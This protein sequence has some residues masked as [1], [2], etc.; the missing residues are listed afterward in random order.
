MIA[1]RYRLASCGLAGGLAAAA[2]TCAAHGAFAADAIDCAKSDLVVT[3]SDVKHNRD[4]SRST[5]ATY[6]SATC[7]GTAVTA[8]YQ[9]R[10]KITHFTDEKSQ[11]LTPD[12]SGNAVIR[13]VEQ[14]DPGGEDITV[15]VKGSDGD[16][17][18]DAKTIP[19]A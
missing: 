17:T 3:I 2:L 15:T 16:V 5:V 11:T 13:R 4:G 19:K 12:G 7:K 14:M 6:F 1:L 18:S 8:G 10:T 9:A